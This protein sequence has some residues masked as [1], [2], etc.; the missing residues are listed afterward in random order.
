MPN[1]SIKT[2]SWDDPPRCEGCLKRLSGWKYHNTHGYFCSLL[3]A[4]AAAEARVAATV[5]S[6]T[7]EC[8]VWVAAVAL[9]LALIAGIRIENAMAASEIRAIYSKCSAEGATQP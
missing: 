9:L 3:C 1:R 5:S 6:P 4:N 8:P 2:S 7:V